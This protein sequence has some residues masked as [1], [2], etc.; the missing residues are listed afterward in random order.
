MRTLPHI[1]TDNSI[2]LLSL[3]YHCVL[4]VIIIK[5]L[6]TYLLL[7]STG[8][9]VQCVDNSAAKNIDCNMFCCGLRVV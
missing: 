5:K 9:G 8:G 1:T 3:Y 7:L 4:T 2:N 6:L